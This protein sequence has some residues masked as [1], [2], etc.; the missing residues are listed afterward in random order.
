MK[1][2]VKFVDTLEDVIDYLIAHCA[3]HQVKELILE[4]SSCP[5]GSHYNVELLKTST[6]V[7]WRKPF[8]MQN[9]SVYVGVDMYNEC[10]PVEPTVLYAFANPEL[11]G[12]ED[13]LKNAKEIRC[14]TL[15]PIYSKYRALRI[16]E[17]KLH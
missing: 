15:P 8:Y 2:L 3:D 13:A 1:T 9:A 16:L 17:G 10:S 12:F 11:A 7:K 6:Y 4:G 14:I 5:I